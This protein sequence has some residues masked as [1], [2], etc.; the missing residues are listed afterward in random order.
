MCFGTLFAQDSFEEYFKLIDKQNHVNFNTLQ[1]PFVN[2]TFE[3]LRQIKIT[4]IMLNKV[5]I[6]DKWY[7]EGDMIDDATISEIN[8]K[9]IKFKYDNLEIAIQINKNDK[10]NIN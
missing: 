7:K 1:N 9:E 6:Y 4:A 3:K 2:P 8:T 10:I 5:K